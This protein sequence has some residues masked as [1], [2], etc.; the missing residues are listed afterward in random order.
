MGALSRALPLVPPPHPSWRQELSGDVAGSVFLFWPG[1]L[2]WEHFHCQ[3][4]GVTSCRDQR[5][6]QPPAVLGEPPAWGISHYCS[7]AGI[8]LGVNDL[9]FMES[10]SLRLEKTSRMA[11]SNLHLN[12]SVAFKP[13]SAPSAWHLDISRGGDSTASLGEEGN[14]EIKRQHDEHCPFPR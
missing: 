5:V 10:E 14:S 8:I 7:H 13:G 1:C 11:E 2:P 12:P 3:P 4:H 9:I 6:S